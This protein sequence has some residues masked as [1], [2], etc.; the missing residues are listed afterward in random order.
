MTYPLAMGKLF[1]EE[2]ELS[3]QCEAKLYLLGHF[4]VSLV[5]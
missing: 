2:F 3:M 4:G 5:D 1:Q